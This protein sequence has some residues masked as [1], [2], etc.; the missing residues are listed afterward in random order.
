MTTAH[1]LERKIM[2]KILL[3][4]LAFWTIVALAQT[5]S[6]EFK[7]Q[8]GHPTPKVLEQSFMKGRNTVFIYI[9]ND[10]AVNPGYDWSYRN[11]LQL[12]NKLEAAQESDLN[13]EEKAYLVK[14]AKTLDFDIRRYQE[15]I[16]KQAEQVES[17]GCGD[18]NNFKTGSVTLTNSRLS[19]P[20]D[21][22]SGVAKM[23]VRMSYCRPNFLNTEF[24][25]GE[26]KVPVHFPMPVD[27]ASN[28]QHFFSQPLLDGLA[29]SDSLKHVMKLFD[30]AKS[31][32]VLWIKGYGDTR[33]V[34]RPLVDVE[35][36]KVSSP[37]LWKALL[38]SKIADDLEPRKFAANIRSQIEDVFGKLHPL[39]KGN[40]DWHYLHKE[41]LLQQLLN[42][43]LGSFNNFS[44][45]PYVIL[46]T[47][48]SALE[49]S[50][51][52]RFKDI[53]ATGDS[54][55]MNLSNVGS[56]CTLDTS[57]SSYEAVDF[58]NLFLP[59]GVNAAEGFLPHLARTLIRD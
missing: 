41:L 49:L 20:Y 22:V 34:F 42:N 2:K 51:D 21:F 44:A 8:L 13:D 54:T 57:P 4:L 37:D 9:A 28:T 47:D 15:S 30:P 23:A 38:D 16:A 43:R 58:Q 24:E 40:T 6:S 36:S 31:Q 26:L 18:S 7:C 50:D 27:P 29:W 19:A 10:L 48:S 33:N 53:F 52:E 55:A 59:L 35:I 14:V 45:F 25:R 1:S 3:F 46:E 17:I 39:A 12:L 56:I 32:F 5:P 11:F